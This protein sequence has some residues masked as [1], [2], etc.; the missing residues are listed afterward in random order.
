M[1][2]EKR[3]KHYLCSDEEQLF[4]AE[5]PELLGC[6]THGATRQEAL[7]NIQDAMTSWIDTVI[8]L[9]RDSAAGFFRSGHMD[10]KSSKTYRKTV[11]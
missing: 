11:R 8:E 10:K 2:H 7:D 4:I 9:G 5:A 1:N 3:R 6:M